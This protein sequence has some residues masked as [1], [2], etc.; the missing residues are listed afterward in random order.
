MNKLW[1]LG[2]TAMLLF[3]CGCAS[4]APMADSTPQTQFAEEVRDMQSDYDEP[5]ITDPLNKTAWFLKGMYHD[6][7]HQYDRALESFNKALSLD[8]AYADAWLAKGITLQ[9]LNFDDMAGTCFE[10]AVKYDPSLAVQVRS[11][12]ENRSE[13]DQIAVS[14]AE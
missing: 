7:A 14:R 13:S 6:D 4:E 2:I 12:L 3:C 8:P 5:V 9:N 1:L 11:L 10:M